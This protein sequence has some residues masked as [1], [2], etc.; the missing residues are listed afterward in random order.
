ML[1]T[2][3]L[4]ALR[5]NGLPRQTWSTSTSSTASR[6]HASPP[7][8]R[9]RS[10]PHRSCPLGALPQH[11]DGADVRRQCW[12]ARAAATPSATCSRTK[13]ASP[14]TPI[15][16]IRPTT[17][18]SPTWAT[19][20]ARLVART[21]GVRQWLV[22]QGHRDPV[23]QAGLRICEA[24]PPNFAG[25]A[26][27]IDIPYPGGNTVPVALRPGT[28][29]LCA[30]PGWRAGVR[31]GDWR[32]PRDLPTSSSHRPPLFRDIV[33]DSS[34]TAGCEHQMRVWRFCESSVTVKSMKASEARPGS[35][36]LAG[37]WRKFL[38]PSNRPELGAGGFA[39]SRTLPT[40]SP[41]AL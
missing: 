9:A 39:E 13:S 32:P 15:S 31:P 14:S 28:G 18:T 36:P 3:R 4:A 33:E 21:D 8:T 40:N 20:I 37:S 10:R 2:M 6:S 1:P 34:G 11:L 16:T 29:R 35:P 7:C 23:E 22:D 5:T 30:L 26:T 27:V 24:T 25:D 19:T 12:F 17:A 41:T 38:F